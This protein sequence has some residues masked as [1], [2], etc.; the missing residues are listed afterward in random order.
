M[1]R[2]ILCLDYGLSNFHNLIAMAKDGHKVFV[3][4]G[5]Y[6]KSPVAYYKSLGITTLDNYLSSRESWLHKFIEVEDINTIINLDPNREVFR[7]K[8]DRNA[9]DYIG[10]STLG[11]HLETRKLWCRRQVG[12]LGVKLPR[13][14][15]TVETP[16]V[17]KPKKTTNNMGTVSCTYVVLGEYGKEWV[18]TNPSPASIQSCYIE[19]YI[20]NAIETNVEFVVSGGKW[21]IQHCQQTMGE[22]VS[23]LVGRTTH[24]TNQASYAKLTGENRDLTIENATKILDW[25]ATLGGSFQGQ[26]TGLIKNGEWYFSEINSRLAVSNSLPI[27]CTGDEYLRSMLEGEPDIIGNAFPWD[28]QKIVVQPI[29]PDAIYPFHLHE[30]HGV[31]VPCGLDIIDGEYR[32]SKLFRPYSSDGCIGIV[33]CDREIPLDFIKEFENNSNFSVS[34]CFI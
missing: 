22:E 18:R 31:S 28:V 25:V 17:I 29:T 19:E 26:L 9:A 20:S 32:V 16:C 8:H 2:R 1:K 10:L 30:K 4:S 15:D 23:K 14:L 34:H 6:D 21:S 11:C 27:F 5:D 33:I 12:K 13:L 7:Q 24:W 3:T